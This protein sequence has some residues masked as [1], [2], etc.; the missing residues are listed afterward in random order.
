MAALMPGADSTYKIVAKGNDLVPAV[1][2]QPLP[3]S[4]ERM[5]FL[6]S[7]FGDRFADMTLE[8]VMSLN[9]KKPP[10]GIANAELLVVR[11]Q[12]LDSYGESMNLYQARKHMSGI[13]GEFVT[14]T[15]RLSRLG[16]TT[17]IFAADHGHV[18]LPEVPA[19]D[20]VSK[21]PGEWT[22]VKRRSLLGHSTG[23]ASGVVVLKT[24]HLG[25]HAPVP[26]MA[27]ATGFRVFKS[28]AGY[29]HEGMSLPEC[30][31]PVVVVNV[32]PAPDISTM[33][34]EVSLHYRS[35][36]FTSRVIGLKVFFN[37]LFDASLVIRVEAYD[38]S[39]SKAKVVGEA[40]DCDARDPV[41]G[42]IA[43][44]RGQHT[45]IPLR[46]DD[47]FEGRAIEVRAIDAS[48]SG[49]VLARLHIEKRHGD[50]GGNAV[51]M[52][53]LDRKLTHVFAG[54]VVRK[55]LLHQLKGGE[56]VPSYVLEYLLGRYCASEDAEEI[57]LG[58]EAVKDT[59]RKNYF[60]HDEANKAQSLVEQNG[61]HRFIDRVE[62]RFLPSETK[63]WASME[64]FGF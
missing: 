22:F 42:L 57:R 29:F 60:R 19:G 25:M 32:A 16:F 14:A 33:G 20:T 13:L 49:V 39:G 17:F 64:N 31:L 45:Q 24:E 44:Q 43:L 7:R 5:A 52:D 50:V 46:L 28:G 38:G 10:K 2:D 30:V 12:E 11:T 55:D 47:D 4:K 9:P 54:K 3:G 63:Y 41:T 36:R 62:V 27:V 18:L 1:G 59:L 15:N 48:G 6:K 37:S 34:T 61:K 40:A 53:A 21:P 8:Q 26:E 23:S 56:N 35:D 58:I 51:Q